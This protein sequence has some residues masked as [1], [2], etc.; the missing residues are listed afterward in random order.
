MSKPSKNL[1]PIISGCFLGAFLHSSHNLGGED[2]G[3]S[4]ART[5]RGSDDISAVLESPD[6]SQ[7]DDV[8]GCAI[9]APKDL[10]SS[11]GS[12][13]C[14]TGQLFIRTGRDAGYVRSYDRCQPSQPLQG[15]GLYG[16]FVELS[17][18]AHLP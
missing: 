13:G 17:S 6:E 9:R 16:I 5:E 8:F 3:K 2:F 4:L 1:R 12:V 18:S 11:Q 14:H 15:R 7:S 10:V